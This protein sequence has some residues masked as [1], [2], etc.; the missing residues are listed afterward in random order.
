MIYCLPAN[1]FKYSVRIATQLG[2]A[3]TLNF[4]SLLIHKVR[5]LC[6]LLPTEGLGL[7]VFRDYCLHEQIRLCVIVVVFLVLYCIP[8]PLKDEALSF[9]HRH[10]HKPTRS[11]FY[12]KNRHNIDGQT[13]YERMDC[14]WVTSS[15]STHT[16]RHKLLHGFLTFSFFSWW[17]ILQESHWNERLIN[18]LPCHPQLLLR[19]RMATTKHWKTE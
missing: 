1:A 16:R 2:Y 4:L 12:S 14:V 15:N 9:T 5:E 11:C 6:C 3:V 13:W 10:T 17:W 19:M 7:L 8:W 18:T